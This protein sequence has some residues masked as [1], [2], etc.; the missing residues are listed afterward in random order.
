MTSFSLSLSITCLSV[1]ACFLRS[2]VVSHGFCREFFFKKRTE[3]KETMMV[4]CVSQCLHG[5]RGLS[6]FSLS[7]DEAASFGPLVSYGFSWWF[8]FF[9][10][11]CRTSY[12][13]YSS[14]S[15]SFHGF[16]LFPVSFLA[17]FL[18]LYFCLFVL[19]F[20][21]ELRSTPLA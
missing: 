13:S 4:V 12:G 5:L 6:L 8:S 17:F 21:Q 19:E 2:Q 16:P 3:E 20:V 7:T 1:F 9:D 18:C 10:K 14:T 11:H 15:S